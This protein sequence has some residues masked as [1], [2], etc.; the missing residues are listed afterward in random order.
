MSKKLHLRYMKFAWQFFLL[1]MY[2][3]GTKWILR[4]KFI[5]YD[6]NYQTYDLGFV[7]YIL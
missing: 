1:L 6:T 3:S 7:I 4:D 2:L 5:V